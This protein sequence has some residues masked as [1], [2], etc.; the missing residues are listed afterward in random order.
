V[1]PA[2]PCNQFQSSAKI[3]NDFFREMRFDGGVKRQT[4]NLLV[5]PACYASGFGGLIMSQNQHGADL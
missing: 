3:I 1:G 4:D 5:L 2:G